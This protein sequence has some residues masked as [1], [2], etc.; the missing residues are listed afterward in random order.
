[1]TPGQERSALLV[2]TP[3]LVRDLQPTPPSARVAGGNP[4]DFVA[5]G[6]TRFFVAVDSL[7]GFELWKSDGTPEGTGMVRDIV[8][9]SGS[10]SVRELTAS[11]GRLYFIARNTLGGD[12]LWRS[13]GTAAG[14]VPVFADPS[15][16]PTVNE[17]EDVSGRLYFTTV[18]ASD[19]HALWVS[20]GT[21][22][23]T[24]LIKAFPPPV[25]GTSPADLRAVKG[26]LY[27]SADDGVH[28]TELWKSDGTPEGTVLVKDLTPG[29]VSTLVWEL[30]AAE[31]V[32]YFST[33]NQIWKS[34]GTPEGTVPLNNLLAGPIVSEGPSLNASFWMA[35]V[36]E[37]LY[38]T[39]RDATSGF[40]L[41]KSDGTP[42]GTVRVKDIHPS[43]DSGPSY[44]KAVNGTLV[45]WAWHPD[46][47]A[48]VWKSDG[49]PEGTVRLTDI[50]LGETT[51]WLRGPFFVA[52]SRAYFFAHHSRSG[53][54]LWMSDGTPAGTREVRIGLV[55]GGFSGRPSQ[56][57]GSADGTLLFQANDGVHGQELWKTDGTPE[58]TLLV[59][60]LNL[61]ANGGAPGHLM[62]LGGGRVLFSLSGAGGLELWSSDGT[63]AGT[64][65]LQEGVMNLGL[66]SR[67]VGGVRYFRASTADEGGNALWRS[68]GTLEGT[69]LVQE[70]SPGGSGGMLQVEAELAGRAFFFA[71]TP[72]E[73]TELWASDGTP[74]GTVLVKDLLPGSGS[75]VPSNMLTVGG[76]LYFTADDG[77]HGRELWKS[78]GT[79]AG[80]VLVK[81]LVPG[82]EGAFVGEMENLNGTLVF[83]AN[84]P[85]APGKRG[86][87]RLGADGQPRKIALSASGVP[88]EEPERMRVV[89][90]TLLL[91][92]RSSAMPELWSYDG[93]SEQATLL[94]S[95]QFYYLLDLAAAGRALYFLAG[96]GLGGQELW[97]SDGTVAGTFKVTD[98]PQSFMDASYHP[99]SMLGLA[100]RGQVLLRSAEAVTGV[101]MWASDGSGV[102]THLVADL[103]PGPRT[104][105]P[106]S[107]TRSG[108]SVFFRADDG[109]H[110]SEL[111]RLPLPPVP[112]DTTLPVLVCPAAVTVEAPSAAGAIASWPG[113]RVSD[114]VSASI[115]L[116]YSH[117]PG[118]VFPLGK[119]VVTVTATDEA[120]NVAGCAFDVRVRDSL[121][122]AVS[123]P[124]DVEVEATGSGTPVSFAE[125][126]ASDGVTARP[127]VTYSHAS[128]SAFPV[129]TTAVTA[130]ARDEAGNEATCSFR[131][132]VKDS[133]KPTVTCPAALTA[134]AASATGARV[135]YAATASDN[136]S[137]VSVAYAPAPGSELALG[138]TV[139]TVTARDGS[140]NEAA[141]S[142]SVTVRDGTAPALTC[143]EAV[144]VEATGA[145]GAPVTF[146]A[147]RATDAVTASPEVTYSQASDSTFPVG[148]SAVTVTARD[149]AGNASA[150]SFSIVVRDTTAPVL[151]CPADVVVVAQGPSGAAVEYPAA[152][153]EDTVTARPEV[154]YSLAPGST[155]PV[156][157]TPVSATVADAAGNTAS[158]SFH[159]SVR[160]VSADAGGLGCAAAG[161][162]PAGL[163]GLWLLLAWPSLGRARTRR[164]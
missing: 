47:G 137:P 33:G 112:A 126:T 38:F 70:F 134:E 13:D 113:A 162:S 18:N 119:T 4:Q 15:F 24:R 77:M 2:G 76:T 127:E 160:S 58:G 123:C 1:V 44:L 145:A 120:G 71:T 131:V 6:T 72:G 142:F 14:T 130:T 132:T 88:L 159:V 50:Q 31:G 109:V 40:E 92:S 82:A 107:Y 21:R 96:N 95:G 3:G 158:C 149:A 25:W 121:A 20:D 29:P 85:E 56:A 86:L 61:G 22:E 143:P 73:G 103:A 140:G 135:T 34:D 7:H 133:V 75:S 118:T 62:D 106:R 128:G 115:P 36:G 136:A 129:G 67:R 110:G 111:W 91:F 124:A 89:N 30:I 8:P 49:T 23:G 146:A 10:P 153:A 65:R 68:D 138:T 66:M 46:T 60:D 11:L 87:W 41:W 156:G 39:A 42:K 99:S 45:F 9:G 5:V 32:F 17:L 12:R 55:P 125:A 52:G 147:A 100:D 139:V 90:G 81:D 28:G 79:A 116:T 35:L 19:G 48:G 97:R 43:G 16:Q 80:T 108:D 154:T 117:V 155:F 74:E 151:T 37:T 84:E 26:T 141:C 98:A 51:E 93:T 161:G 83:T 104:S 27:F 57:V 144:T 164:G 150:C 102:G 94:A 163:L 148:E 78:D 54:A 157:T 53:Y 69:F 101:E 64:R 63:E 59:K 152:T 105:D 122:P 114:D